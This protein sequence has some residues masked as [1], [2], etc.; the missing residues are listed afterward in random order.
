MYENEESD[1]N[2]IKRS[3]CEEFVLTINGIVAPDEFSFYDQVEF[4]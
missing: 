2:C 1:F 4:V 3:V